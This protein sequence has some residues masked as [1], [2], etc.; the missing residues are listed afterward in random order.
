[1]GFRV[2]PL[3]NFRSLAS[4]VPFLFS[5]FYLISVNEVAVKLVSVP[6]EWHFGQ[7]L[8]EVDNG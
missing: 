3:G 2:N 1:M 6:L 8:L 7:S 5:G 4:V